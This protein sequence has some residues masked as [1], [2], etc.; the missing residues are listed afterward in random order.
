MAKLKRMRKVS[1]TSAVSTPRRIRRRL[2]GSATSNMGPAK[3]SRET[4]RRTITSVDIFL[5]SSQPHEIKR[6]GEQEDGE[7]VAHR[8]GQDRLVRPASAD[9]RKSECRGNAAD[10][11]RRGEF[12]HRHAR[13]SGEKDHGLR[14]AV[15][16]ATGED[17][18]PSTALV[19]QTLHFVQRPGPNEALREAPRR[20]EHQAVAEKAAG[21]QAEAAQQSAEQCSIDN[22]KRGNH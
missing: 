22:T 2:T 8:E 18:C 4:V 7:H 3:A 1:A 9:G 20:G 17:N 21:D 15:G 14:D 19:E 12:S 5:L 13:K 6:D 16:K 10:G 11:Q